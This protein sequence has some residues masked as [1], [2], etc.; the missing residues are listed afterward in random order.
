MELCV[1]MFVRTDDDYIFKIVEILEKAKYDDSNNEEVQ[2]FRIDRMYQR[3]SKY[4]ETDYIYSDWITKASANYL[5]LLEVG[6]VVRCKIKCAIETSGWL[7]GVTEIE[8]EE[9]L[10]NLKEDKNFFVI[11]I[12]GKQRFKE[13][14]YVIGE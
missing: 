3:N 14:E 7:K 5:N 4:N 12:V 1:G 10:K 9:M 2:R 6:D 11:S 8:S 13:I